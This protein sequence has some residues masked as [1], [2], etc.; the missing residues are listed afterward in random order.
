MT[1]GMTRSSVDALR[2]PGSDRKT[3]A[4]ILKFAATTGNVARRYVEERQRRGC[5][6]EVRISRGKSRGL[7]AVRNRHGGQFRTAIAPLT[8]LAPT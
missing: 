1:S 8:P 6:A 5:R 7:F 2:A 3:A 4:A